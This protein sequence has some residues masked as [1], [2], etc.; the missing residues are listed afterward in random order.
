MQSEKAP[1][2]LK[3][4]DWAGEMGANW[5]ANLSRFESM[6][7]PIGAALL[8]RADYQPGERVLD[9]GCGG[10]GTTLAIGKAVAPAGE[11]LGIDISPDLAA[12][13]TRR[14]AEA[15]AGNVRFTC[16][17]A[18]STTLP[19]APFDRLFSRFG[20]MFFAD[21]ISAFTNLRRPL[22]PGARI[23]LGVWAAPRDNPWM[24]EAMVI[25]RK[26][27]DLP[28]PVPRAP[29]PFAFEDLDYVREILSGAG[30]ADPDVT[31]YEGLQPVGGAGSTPDQALDFVM[32]G[33]A[34]GRAL[35][36][37]SEDVRAIAGRDLLALFSNHYETGR[38]VLM[39]CKVW[40]VTT[41][42]R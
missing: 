26:Y 15:D 29:G 25:V 38:G 20:C 14:A 28:P 18:S 33:M 12:Y 32:T 9:I 7:A 6:L 34:A 42:A 2:T 5:L 36:D 17:D 24:S 31:S 37:Q 27:V 40:L 23:D 21:P 22:K 39:P 41:T 35:A 13:A 8:A 11:A 19:D 16:I 30:F 1:D 10:G 3:A 4:D